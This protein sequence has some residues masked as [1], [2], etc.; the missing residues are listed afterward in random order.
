MSDFANQLTRGSLMKHV[1][2][3]VILSSIISGCT[4]SHIAQ[5]HSSPAVFTGIQNSTLTDISP[6]FRSMFCEVLDHSDIKHGSC[7]EF[8]YPYESE[9]S[10]S[11]IDFSLKQTQSLKNDLL[12]VLVPGIFGECLIKEVPPFEKAIEVV[13]E[14]LG[15]RTITLNKISGRASSE[16]YAKIIAQAI[17]NIS[18][19]N[20]EKIVLVGYSKGVTDSLVYLNNQLSSDSKSKKI[21]AFVSIT[22]V[23][24]GT[25]IADKVGGVGDKIASA[26]PLDDCPTKDQ[27]GIPSLSVKQRM[28]WMENHPETF[29][30]SIPMFTVASA[31]TPPKMSAIFV[32]FETILN[33]NAG[34][35]DGQVNVVN[36]MLPSSYFLGVLHADHW[37]VILPFSDKENSDLTFLNKIVRKMAT[38]NE[39]PREVL[40]E[41]I[42]RTV[43]LKI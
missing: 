28:N 5:Y 29:Q 33:K 34:P 30:T 6:E 35:N 26:L 24:N 40:L 12:V 20:N 21:S 8:F 14:R 4:R 1:F 16:Y 32:P 37:A 36:Q 43:D 10:S 7:N 41:S 38:R 42:I 27:S 11:S 15:V 19:E 22:G 18:I 17:Q 31:A 39:F 23:V 2:L 3:I 9:L 25:I 13:A